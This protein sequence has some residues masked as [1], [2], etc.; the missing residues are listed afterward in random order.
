MS[1][2]EHFENEG[3][4]AEDWARL[5]DEVQA[6]LRDG[7]RVRRTLRAAAS[8]ANVYQVVS[9]KLLVPEAQDG[10]FTLDTSN[11]QRPVRL[12]ADFTVQS[13]QMADSETIRALAVA[14]AQKLA[15][16][17]DKALM[18]GARAN[19]PPGLRAKHLDNR[20][21]LYQ[22]TNAQQVSA[23]ELIHDAIGALE[24]RG[25]TGPYVVL[26]MPDLWLESRRIQGQVLGHD[27]LRKLIGADGELLPIQ[28]SG[29]G[30]DHRGVVFAGRAV[31]LDLVQVAPASISL[32]SYDDGDLRLR[33][34]EQFALRIQEPE[35]VQSIHLAAGAQA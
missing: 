21:A 3:W 26:M 23:L 18:L 20:H 30:P 24:A 22:D 34:E 19:L 35:A 32:V 13:E 14:A 17:E 31:G 11:T 27:L 1:A 5:N 28:R 15:P 16:A 33:V 6:I 4:S 12:F 9:P 8:Q 2:F 7:A 25:Y 10:A 29:P